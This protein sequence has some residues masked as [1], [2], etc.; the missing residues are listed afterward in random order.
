MILAWFENLFLLLA[1]LRPE[2]ARVIPLWAAPEVGHYLMPRP[3]CLA[4]TVDETRAR[5]DRK[6]IRPWEGCPTSQ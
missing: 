3:V 2:P 6:L 4:A 1:G 5:S